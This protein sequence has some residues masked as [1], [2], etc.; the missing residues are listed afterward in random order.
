MWFGNETSYLTDCPAEAEAVRPMNTEARTTI[1]MMALPCIELE[2]GYGFDGARCPG[3]ACPGKGGGTAGC[4]QR[5]FD[6]RKE[7]I[8]TISRFSEDLTEEL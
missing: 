5:I 2:L 3:Q 6:V 4:A 7:I 1:R 8:M